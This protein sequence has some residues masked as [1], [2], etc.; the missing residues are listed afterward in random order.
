MVK[1]QILHKI[2]TLTPLTGWKNVLSNYNNKFTW[3]VHMERK[4]SLTYAELVNKW[5]NVNFSACLKQ[6]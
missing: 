3:F 5:L 4:P 1:L 2:H 6:L